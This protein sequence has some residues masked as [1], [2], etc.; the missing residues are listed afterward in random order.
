MSVNPWVASS[1]TRL[2]AGDTAGAYADATR[3]TQ[4]SPGDWESH[5]QLARA[6]EETGAGKVARRAAERWIKLRPDDWRA[7]AAAG[8]AHLSLGHPRRA[9]SAFTHAWRLNPHDDGVNRNLAI[10][11]ATLGRKERRAALEEVERLVDAGTLP[12][13]VLPLVV[14]ATV[15]LRTR[16]LCAL[17]AWSTLGYGV[18]VA[19]LHD[20][21]VVQPELWPAAAAGVLPALALAA[22]W[23]VPLLK[24]FTPRAR[25]LLPGMWRRDALL[26]LEVTGNTVALALLVAVPVVWATAPADAVLAT[27]IVALGLPILTEIIV[28]GFGLGRETSGREW[29]GLLL[30][31]PYSL[32]GIVIVVTGLSV[33]RMVL[34]LLALLLR[35]LFRRPAR[36]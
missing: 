30:L 34:R 4:E 5:A 16:W 13:A 29:A 9:R 28:V 17:A 1:R 3:A 22:L 23:F 27:A 31:P 24:R 36:A 2:D 19:V 21:G 6:A 32:A 8:E 33:V 15:E 18:Y 12:A 26:A 14:D 35:P 11:G 7:Y 25:R 10:L 20:E